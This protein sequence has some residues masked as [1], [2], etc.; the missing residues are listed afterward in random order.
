MTPARVPWRL[1]D[2]KAEDGW[3]IYEGNRKVAAFD[4]LEDA[5]TAVA[6]VNIMRGLPP[7]EPLS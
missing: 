4:R 3:R 1:Q 6:A 5:Q 7:G 2:E